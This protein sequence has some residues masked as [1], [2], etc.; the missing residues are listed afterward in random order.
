MDEITQNGK[1]TIADVAQAL[2]VSKTTVSRAI[3]GKGR[4]GAATREAV[5]KYINEHNYTPSAIAKGLAQSKTFNVSWVV[6][7]DYSIAELPFFQ[8]CLLGI[9]D[10]ASA[11]E[12]DIII[13]MVNNQDISRLKRAVAN[14]KIDGAILSR[15]L[16][17]DVAAEYLKEMNIP[18]VA[19]GLSDI[20]NVIQID[21]D[22]R[23]GCKELISLLILKG[24]K[25]IGLIGGNSSHM[26]TR[27]RLDG[28]IEG[29][30]AAGMEI[31]HDLIY[32]DV[33]GEA[34]TGKAVEELVAKK[35]DC[36][37]C[38]DDSLCVYTLNKLKAWGISV[39]EDIRVASFYNSAMLDLT[40]SNVT[41]LSFDAVELGKETFKI[42]YDLMDGKKVAP[43]TLLGYGIVLKESTK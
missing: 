9:S 24:C 40:A 28:Y 10:M 1:I 36:I 18:F 23:G 39:P 38:M 7:G 13:S 30:M 21:N 22:H 5:L 32:L 37:V 25:N 41:A 6:P 2:G 12:Y 43:K 42:L 26:V 4:I 19:I 3:S 15:T 31:N 27:N 8:N 14:H 29:F 35:A 33:E 16:K 11:L 34:R 17:N 20:D